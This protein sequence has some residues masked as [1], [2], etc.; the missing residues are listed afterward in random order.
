MST[1]IETAAA[2]LTAAGYEVKIRNNQDAGGYWATGT[3]FSA[4]QGSK[5]VTATPMRDGAASVAMFIDYGDWGRTYCDSAELKSAAGIV[6]RA[7]A[8]LGAV[9]VAA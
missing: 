4:R 6:R 8:F 7:A 5:I 3:A 9:K 2:R 1:A